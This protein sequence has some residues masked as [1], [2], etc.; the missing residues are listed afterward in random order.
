[1]DIGAQ[2]GAGWESGMDNVARFGFIS[3][4]QL[5]QYANKHYKGDIK[6]ARGDWQVRFFENFATNSNSS[7]LSTIAQGCPQ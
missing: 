2:H 4:T 7:R 6:K 3:Q 1:M 5:K